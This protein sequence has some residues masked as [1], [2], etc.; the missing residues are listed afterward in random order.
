M[1]NF[2]SENTNLIG[3]GSTFDIAYL[4]FI[5]AFKAACCKMLIERI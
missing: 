2:C 5:K 3:K 1:I 4:G